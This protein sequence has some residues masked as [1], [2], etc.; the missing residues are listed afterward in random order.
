MTGNRAWADH[1]DRVAFY[2]DRR[3]RPADL[4]PAERRFLPRLASRGDSVLEAGCSAAGFS[5]IFVLERAERSAEARP[6]VCIDLPF[7]WPRALADHATVL[8]AAELAT[9]VP[10]EAL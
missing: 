6:T 7:A 1:P 3:R 2:A 10:E 8:P 4:Y 9:L 5:E